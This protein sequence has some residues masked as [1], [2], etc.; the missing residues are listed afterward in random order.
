MPDD[1]F[2]R[3]RAYLAD[4]VFAIAPGEIRSPTD[5]ID[6]ESWDGLVDLP[7]DVLLRT[8]D[9]LGTMLADA[10]NQW[11][12]WIEAMPYEPE[13]P[14]GFMFDAALDAADEFHA[15]PFIAAHGYYRQATAGLRNAL[16]GVTT[17]AA[18]AVHG[19]NENFRRWREGTY[20]PAFGNM[21]ERLAQAP[22]PV[23]LDAVLGQ[24]G[25]FGRNPDGLLRRVYA[26]LCRY[27]H[28]RPGHTNGDIWQSHGPVF[29]GN[30]FTRFWEDLCDTI[31][32]CYVLYKIGWP[33][34]SLPGD[35]RSLF[36]FADER[37]GGLG[38]QLLEHFFPS[39][40]TEECDR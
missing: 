9:Y 40:L 24:P 6:E 38:S 22:G 21:V 3:G 2:R 28:S 35:A 14:G 23:G 31:A 27:A 29:V 37:W 7:T 1:D 4:E 36:G 10:Q 19:D 17:A 8:T 12:R 26:G 13:E 39:A 16:E 25:V 20:E 30:G 11:G 18:L 32:L 15:A 33:A 5:R 34:L